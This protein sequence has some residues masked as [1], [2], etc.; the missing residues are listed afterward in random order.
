MEHKIESID[1]SHEGCVC[2]IELSIDKSCNWDIVD[3]VDCDF[4]VINP[5]TIAE[6]L[7]EKEER[8]INKEINNL[9]W[10]DDYV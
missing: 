2:D 3:A 10:S 9:K 8:F 4:I 5:I 6:N 1:I 7:S